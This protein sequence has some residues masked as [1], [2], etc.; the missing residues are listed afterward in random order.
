MSKSIL[1]LEPFGGDSHASFY[2]GWQRYSTHRFTILELPARHWKWRSRHA[3]LTLALQA[4]ERYRAGER[5]DLI[6]CSSMLNLPEWLGCLRTPVGQVPS[7]LYFHENQFSYPLSAGQ[8]RD[9]HLAYNHVLSV[10][11]ASELWFNSQFHLEQFRGAANQWLKRMPDF[12]HL[13]TFGAGLERARICPPGIDPP[14]FEAVA[15]PAKIPRIGWVARWEHDKRPDRFCSAMEELHHRGVAFRLIL[16]GQQFQRL[17]AELKRLH[18][19][20]DVVEHCGFAPSRQAYWQLLRQI[21]CVVSTADHEFFGIAVLE[22][23]AAG[24]QPL[25]PNRLAYP[26]ILDSLQI[27]NAS[28]HVY[29]SEPELISKLIDWCARLVLPRRPESLGNWERYL[30]RRLAPVYD[31]RV[32]TLLAQDR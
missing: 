18:A 19:L 24:A 7:I 1:V 6:F 14:H 2:R 4:D 32:R 21:D 22:A 9:Y 8:Q 28:Q 16:L 20:P 5:F 10:C 29:S 23:I 27:R 30:W 31:E 13:E 15:R 17:P 26:E 11:V 12:S 25:L 3:S